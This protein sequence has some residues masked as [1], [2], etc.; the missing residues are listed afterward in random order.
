MSKMAK[1]ELAQYK[2]YVTA[3]LGR[4]SPL[5]QDYALGDFSENIEIP[6]EENEFTELLVGL[7]LMVDDIREIMQEKEDTIA[8]LEQA[9]EKI[10]EYSDTFCIEGWD[11][12]VDLSED[13]VRIL[14]QALAEGGYSAARV[15]Y[16]QADIILVETDVLVVP[17]YHRT[18]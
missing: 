11:P 13:Y 8:R 16:V 9:E 10:K 7:N 3:R 4:L 18:R 5:L 15:L 2:A 6:E 1:S 17:I 12:Y 14:E